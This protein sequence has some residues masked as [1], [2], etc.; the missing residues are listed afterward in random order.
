MNRNFFTAGISLI[1]VFFMVPYFYSRNISDI[2][3]VYLEKTEYCQQ[4]E[5]AGNIE[6]ESYTPI[7][8]SYPVFVK[9]SY[10]LENSF[11]N[12]GQLMFVLDTE[13]MSEMIKNTDMSVYSTAGNN[14][15]KSF[16]L[17]LDK[18]V[19]ATESGVV[20]EL[21][22]YDGSIVMADENFCIIEQSDNLV[23]KIT[24]EQ[25]KYTEVSVGDTV[26]FTPSI[27]PA[28]K[29][30]G[31][32]LGKTAVVRKENSLTGSKTVVDVFASVDDADE[33]IIS[34]ADV[35]GRIIKEKTEIFTLPYEYINQDEKGEYVTVYSEEK[36]RKVYI[37]T[38]KELTET[39]EI[40]T[41]FPENTMFLNVGEDDKERFLLINGK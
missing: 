9:E 12:K 11:V 38:G 10:V 20:K 28:R 40:L 34:G 35:T 14:M 5:F 7:K 22:A 29:Y 32:V 33:Y 1:A 37:E 41:Y 15:D 3:A 36:N 18:N 8:L 2:E 26:E 23:L 27:A 4:L 16:V 17:N 6:A 24:L 21:I 31:T 30:T 25:E 19:Y 13:K 39:V